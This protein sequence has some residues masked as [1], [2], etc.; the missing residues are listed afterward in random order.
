MR[1]K[2]DTMAVIGEADL[3][4]VFENVGV[5]DDNTALVKEF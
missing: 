4:D 1:P 5:L 2:P 3:S